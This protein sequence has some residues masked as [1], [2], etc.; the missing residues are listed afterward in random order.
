MQ[1]T[2][3]VAPRARFRKAL[4]S[5]PPGI[6]RSADVFYPLVL[7]GFRWPTQPS[8]FTSEPQ[9]PPELAW[10]LPA[11]TMAYRGQSG[12]T[13]NARLRWAHD[14]GTLRLR[15]TPRRGIATA[16]AAG[17]V[18]SAASSAAAGDVN[19][20]SASANAD[21][22]ALTAGLQEGAPEPAAIA[23]GGGLAAGGAATSAAP[24]SSAAS[25]S[26]AP[27]L[28]PATYD[29]R[30]SELQ[31]TVLLWTEA[32]PSGR[33]PMSLLAQHTG[34]PGELACK[35]AGSLTC[36]PGCNLLRIVG[37]PPL[38]K[39]RN[40]W[41]GDELEVNDDFR[42]AN[43]SYRH[44]QAAV[45]HEVEQHRDASSHLVCPSLSSLRPCAHMLQGSRSVHVA[46]VSLEPPPAASAED[47]EARRKP[48]LDVST[49]CRG[50]PQARGR[51]DSILVTASSG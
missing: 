5:A 1:D 48:V 18:L 40:P 13:S 14:L 35:L 47:I 27:L 31:G 24:P 12:P 2:R 26:P 16:A 22:G 39:K 29:V 43:V 10:Y 7:T 28:S 44:R 11:F 32:Q 25:P 6:S 23:V 17:E 19:A 34:L 46:R 4:A 15:F 41:M 3:L 38:A 51:K 36:A 37:V 45:K 9:L 50:P 20:A 49:V 30:C 8:P 42:T 21:D 33:Y